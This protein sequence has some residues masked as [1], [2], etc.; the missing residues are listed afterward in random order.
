LAIEFAA[1]AHRGQMRKGT[2]T[3]Y[4]SHPYAVGMILQ[5]AKCSEEVVIA[6]LLHDTLED[7]DTTEAQLLELFGDK[8]LGLVLGASEP[9][10][11]QSWE[12]RK[13]H[14]LDYLKT[15]PADLRQLACADKLHN[16]RS[17]VRDVEAVGDEA[18]NR[19]NRGYA[20]QKWY[21]TELVESLGYA[22]RFELLDAFQDEVESFFLQKEVPSA[23]QKC[24]RNKK[25]YDAVFERLFADPQRV[26][27]LDQDLLKIADQAT[28]N[29]V[30]ETID[31]FLTGNVEQEAIKQ[32][33]Y[34]YLTS[35]G[36]EFETNS[37]GTNILISACAAL[38]EQFQ[39]FPHEVYHHFYRSLKKGVL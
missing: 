35:R 18:W 30:F 21:Y 19:F 37:E 12:N 23:L 1:R 34:A 27:Q 38:Q 20:D 6:G 13:Q 36:I 8:V 25:F 7:T 2:D 29:R 3:P 22:S 39:L 15:A 26:A 11:S 9:D 31:G 17:I 4:I 10:K 32:T 33:V 24:R 14:T 16:L 28:L 5:A